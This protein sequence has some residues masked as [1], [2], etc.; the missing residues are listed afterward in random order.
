M[1]FTT[2]FQFPT[3]IDRWFAPGLGSEI[4][5]GCQS[6]CYYHAQPQFCPLH[7]YTT[8]TVCWQHLHCLFMTQEVTA[9]GQIRA[10]HSHRGHGGQ[11]VPSPEKYLN[12]SESVASSVITSLRLLRGLQLAL[13]EVCLLD[14]SP[15]IICTY[16]APRSK[17][18]RRNFLR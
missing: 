9:R 11:V 7:T 18:R 4:S 10:F 1:V 2:A 16:G 15:G 17:R 6:T 12:H 8:L 3:A 14:V 13:C 5:I